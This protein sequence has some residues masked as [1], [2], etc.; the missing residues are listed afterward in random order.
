M[1]ETCDKAFG[2][3]LRTLRERRALTLDAVVSL[4]QTFPETIH[5]GYLSRCEN[6]FQKPA[7]SKIIALSRIYE[8]PADV[9]VERMELDMEL[10]RIGGPDTAGL[11]FGQMTIRGRESLQRGYRWPAYAFLRDA[12]VTARTEPPQ[13]SFRDVEEQ[14]S[15]AVMSCATAAGA[16]GRHRF[17]IHEFKHL[18]KQ[19]RLGPRLLTLVLERISSC[20]LALGDISAAEHFSDRAIDASEQA[21][22]EEY[23]GH[24]LYARARV[25]LW[26]QDRRKA[27]RLFEQAYEEHKSRDRREDCAL[28][29]NSLAQCYFDLRRRGAARRSCRAAL[30]IADS[31]GHLRTKAFSL[32]LLGE[33]DE[34]A[35]K[36]NLALRRWRAAVQ[37]GKELKDRELRFK[38]E[39]LIF[40]RAIRDENDAVARAI[41]RRL[42]RLAPWIPP[43][44]QE[45][46]EFRNLSHT[47]TLAGVS[48]SQR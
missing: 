23:R 25:A 41:H 4:S 19:I 7:F 31:V 29:L 22:G 35:E 47:V 11:G 5:K 45:L 16:L 37:I 34:L 26:S 30:K 48:R 15:C 42:H 38:A 2:R 40:R 18:K 8:V 33:L 1:A 28:A 36:P 6:G 9:L 39:F 44:T 24:A 46:S 21:G 32:L 12:V 13:L 43:T 17:A 27:V 20:Y 14:Y 3:Y 10:D